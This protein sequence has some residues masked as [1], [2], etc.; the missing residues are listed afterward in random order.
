MKK[1]RV[2]WSEDSWTDRTLSWVLPDLVSRK[3]LVAADQS[4]WSTFWKAEDLS[5]TESACLS[6]E[7]LIKNV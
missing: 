3:M 1:K 2:L 6:V 4:S 7:E 5:T